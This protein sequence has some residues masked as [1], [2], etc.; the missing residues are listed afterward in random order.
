MLWFN[1]ET[2]ELF[3]WDGSEW[4]PVGGSNAPA[5]AFLAEFSYIAEQ[6][7]TVFSGPDIF[8]ATPEF[9]TPEGVNV[10]YNGSRLLDKIDWNVTDGSTL[11]LTKEATKE[12]VVT[13]ELMTSTQEG[14]ILPATSKKIETYRWQFNGVQKTFPI[15]VEGQLFSPGDALNIL[16][17]L[18]GTMQDANIDYAVSGSNIIFDVAPLADTKV[19]AIVGIPIGSGGG[20]GP[21]TPYPAPSSFIRCTYLASNEGQTDFGG[22]DKIGNV[23]SGLQEPGA[24]AIVHVNGVRIEDE[25]YSIVSDSSINLTRGVSVGSSVIIEVFT[26]AANGGAEIVPEH[27]HDCGVF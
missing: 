27:N 9:L 8:G 5:T 7:Q 4:R 2:G 17:S 22:S 23:L 3:V 15:F 25:D 10:F 18:G 20:S 24:I 1:P 16:L 11:V 13:I 26:V 6:G 21:G 12:S 14:S 19:W